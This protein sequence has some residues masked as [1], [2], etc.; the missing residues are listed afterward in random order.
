MRFPVMEGHFRR[1]TP[2]GCPGMCFANPQGMQET[3]STFYRR[4]GMNVSEYMRKYMRPVPGGAIAWR[5]SVFSN[6]EPWEARELIDV[7]V[8]IAWESL[9]SDASPEGPTLEIRK[10]G[11]YLVF[12]LNTDTAQDILERAA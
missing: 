12:S 3:L 6:P 7:A 5:R 4:T 9:C 2:V 8:D 1:F 10:S 11:S